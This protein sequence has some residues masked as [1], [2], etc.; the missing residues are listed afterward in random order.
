MGEPCRIPSLPRWSR[1][2]VEAQGLAFQSMF[3]GTYAED[4]RWEEEFQRS[5]S[6]Y[7][8]SGEIDKTS[9][10]K[11][12]KENPAENRWRTAQ[13]LEWTLGAL[14]GKTQ[15]EANGMANSNT[16]LKI[17]KLPADLQCK[18]FAIRKS[19]TDLTEKEAKGL[20]NDA[21]PKLRNSKSFNSREENEEAPRESQAKPAIIAR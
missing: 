5:G 12:G 2:V 17:R 19:S 11:G 15:T 13:S 9:W 16:R 18:N 21:K 10:S 20:S 4:E 6:C 8:I 3:A 14:H 1:K 7:Q